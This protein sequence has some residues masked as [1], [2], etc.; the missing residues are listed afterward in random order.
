MGS[1]REHDRLTS[2]VADLMRERYSYDRIRTHVEYHRDGLDGEM[3]VVAEN[4]DGRTVYVEVKSW[5]GV[6]KSERQLKRAYRAGV[7]DQFVY[8]TPDEVGRWTPYEGRTN[9]EMQ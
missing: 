9:S 2:R 1:E 3:D 7:A 5:N 4:Y 8:V 6:A